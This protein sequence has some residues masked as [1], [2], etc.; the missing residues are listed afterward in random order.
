MN[1]PR[2]LALFSN[3]F[4]VASIGQLVSLGCSPRSIARARE[5]GLFVRLAPGLYRLAGQ[6]MTFETRAM[7]AQ[8]HFGPSGFLDGTTAGAVHGLRAMPRSVIQATVVGRITRLT[9]NWARAS[10]IAA[11]LD[12]DVELVGSF[13][14]ARPHR[15]LLSLASQF[16]LHRFAR[17]AEDAWH[18]NLVSPEEMADYLE[19]VR[20]PG[21]KGV[22]LI[23]R[24]LATALPRSRPSQSGL[25][26][27][28]IEAMRR[29][30]LP[31]PERQ[32]PVRLRSGDVVHLDFAWPAVKLGV[33]P[34]DT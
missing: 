34:G 29:V 1:D 16:N 17:A 23:D 4:G 18:R 10:S 11:I 21:L 32:Y 5:N 15:T 12:G 13:R 14:L 25:E 27:D 31:E 19:E 7:A 26:L 33:E 2:V 8:L 3:Q 20:R 6:G 24:W 30:G 28:A 22:A 9:P